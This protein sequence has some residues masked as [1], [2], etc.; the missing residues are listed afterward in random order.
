[1]H[2]FSIQDQRCPRCAIRRTAR[3]GTDARS[4]CFNCRYRW[5]PRMP[6]SVEPIRFLAETI[7]SADEL[8]RLR[9][10]RRAVRAGFYSDGIGPSYAGRSLRTAAA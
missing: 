1:M 9:V 7:F 10:Y 2:T 3:V 5:D 8:T 6:S 4:F